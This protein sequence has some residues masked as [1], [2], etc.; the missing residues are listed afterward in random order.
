M[1][2]WVYGKG[3][4]VCFSRI[5]REISH[6]PKLRM[7]RFGSGMMVHTCNLSTWVLR[8]DLAFEA[9]LCCVVNFELIWA[10][11]TPFHQ[12]QARIVRFGYGEGLRE[13]WGTRHSLCFVSLPQSIPPPRAQNARE[14][15][16]CVTKELYIDFI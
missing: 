16:H 13:G 3:D 7:V 15:N 1:I 4:C 5:V 11:E 6:S 2:C 8:Q 9:S 14:V 12:R 10:N